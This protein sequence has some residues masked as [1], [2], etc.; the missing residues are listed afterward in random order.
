VGEG[1]G[2][3]GREVTVLIVK[4]G[5]NYYIDYRY[6]PGRSGKRIRKRVGPKKEEAVILLGDLQ[7][8]I[9]QGENPLLKEI[10]PA[11]FETVLVDF[12]A[13]HL[14]L[15]R[16]PK[17]YKK[18][19]AAL[20]L[21]FTGLMLQGITPKVINDFVAARRAAGA[22]G[23]TVNRQ[24]AVLSRL[25]NYAIDSG[26]YGGENP[27]RKVK[28]FAESPGRVR[29]LDRDEAA[30]LVEGAPKHLRPVLV[31]ALHT[32]GRLREILTLRWEDVDLDRGVLY[33]DQTNTKSGKQREVPI[34][35]DLKAALSALRKVRRINEQPPERVFMR[36][37]KPL[38][39]I[40]TA[41]EKARTNANLAFEKA[42][43]NR[44]LGE[45]VTF[46]VLRHTFASWFMING[47]DLYRLQKYLGHSTI[48]LTQRYAHLSPGYLHDGVRFFGAPV[49][50]Q[51]L[52]GGHAV[53]N[54][55]A[56]LASSP[57]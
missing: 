1:E 24:R 44:N 5:K 48:T 39:D 13:K 11:L 45:D 18:K 55:A 25:F 15:V 57:A 10:K 43:T 30:A 51:A 6:P 16:D 34:S 37:G 4:R 22:S 40:R 29:F 50:A 31:A 41:F 17:S 33:F 20:K 2:P 8:Q 19:T 23:G 3:E 42:R 47:G 46:H 14:P 49:E 26:L 36:H 52:A 38:V 53:D 21:H 54:P 56:P 12:M 7:R 9:R 28:R 32:G 27:V 35:P